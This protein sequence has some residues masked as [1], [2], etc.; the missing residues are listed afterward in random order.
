MPTLVTQIT[1]NSKPNTYKFADKYNPDVYFFFIGAND[2]ND[3][4]SPRP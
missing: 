4:V 2:Y 1:D 3:V